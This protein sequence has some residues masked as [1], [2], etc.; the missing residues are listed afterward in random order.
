MASQY[1]SPFDDLLHT[2]R[3]QFDEVAGKPP[4]RV[5]PSAPSNRVANPPTPHAE[6]EAH[7]STV[8][9]GTASGIAFKLK[10]K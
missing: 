3:R 2:A 4:G 1:S 5:N 10:T 8:I 6:P 9:E 7:P